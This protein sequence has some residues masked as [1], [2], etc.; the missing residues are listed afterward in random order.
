MA[1]DPTPSPISLTDPPADLVEYVEHIEAPTSHARLLGD[2]LGDIHT[3]YEAG[4]QGAW[5]SAT[6]Y[7]RRALDQME[8]AGVTGN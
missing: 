3:A 2:A 8:E 6:T 7:L 5:L 1:T 4:A